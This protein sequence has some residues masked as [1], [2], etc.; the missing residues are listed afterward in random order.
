MNNILFVLLSLSVIMVFS[1]SIYLLGVRNKKQ[2][3]YA[4]LGTLFSLFVWGFGYL[5]EAFYRRIYG[6]TIMIFVYF[7]FIGLLL[8]P[9]FFLLTGIIF[10]K[11]K[12]NFSLK[13][14]LLFIPPIISFLVLITNEYH[15]LFFI[16][17]ST[18]NT[19]VI[20]GRYF[21]F[22][23]IYSYS[24]LIIGMGC[25]LYYS[26]KNSGFFS[27]QSLLV[28]CGSAIPLITNI[29]IITRIIEVPLF[30]TALSFSISMGFIYLAIFRFDFLRAAP[31]ALQTVVDR[32]SDSFVVLNDE[33]QIIDFNKTLTN[34]F[35]DIVTIRRNE[36]LLNI[37][38]G[39]S[40][41]KEYDNLVQIIEN[42]KESG[43]PISIEKHIKEIGFD[44]YFKIE[45]TSILSNKNY[46]GT[47]I[48]FKD[49]TENIKHIEEI[50]EKH[51]IM[52][53]QERLASLGQLIGGI[54]HNLNTP[55]MSIS[56][57]VEGL[58]DLVNEYD[59]SLDDAAVTV[60]DH[61]EIAAEMRV[62]LDKIK[63]YCA[64]MS[65][66]ISAVKGQ[67]RNFNQSI[68]LT[69]TVDELIKRI[70]LLMKYEL[71]RYN[72]ALK[73]LINV[74]KNTELYGDINSL[75]QIFDNIIIN[76]IQAYE[77][78]NG[79]IEFS[80][81]NNNESIL[82]IIKDSAKGIPES[83]K[84]KLLK[85]MVTTKGK[86]G[87]GLGMFMSYSTIRGRFGGKMWFESEVGKGTAF[88]IQLPNEKI[89][90]SLA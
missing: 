22:H 10:S 26:I 24:C 60:G 33:Y 19:D 51:A 18:N 47:I 67:A 54:A 5:V 68:A 72:C 61:H 44:K 1:L 70:E 45:V 57:A 23:S 89:S 82:F 2:I 49:I 16:S 41:F 13:H 86:D 88:F 58:R 37:L 62:W 31:I 80:V 3:H 71:I 28:V 11:T 83:I 63:P 38:E 55:I 78:K 21:L 25:F 79:I 66:I 43:A 6:Q 34:T 64:Y 20:Y 74:D 76:A 69:F 42:A 84:G 40:L 75:V 65:D 90:K 9:V 39:T 14:Y 30:T 12:I 17:F 4:F 85:E 53:E 35:K 73:T 29:I 81:Q 36:S 59:G 56:G 32:I 77:G 7:W 50:E 8:T 87:T 27:K 48:L 15:H 52:M 46:L